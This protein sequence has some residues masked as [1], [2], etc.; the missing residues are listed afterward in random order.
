M[1]NDLIKREH[2]YLEDLTLKLIET[3][4]VRRQDKWKE[5]ILSIRE[6]I[7]SV[8]ESFGDEDSSTWRIHWDHQLYKVLE[9]HYASGLSS[10][11]DRLPDI[12]LDL[13]IRG[14]QI[15]FRPELENAR[16]RFYKEVKR[17]SQ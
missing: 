3:D 10:L 14:D 12:Q 8:K 13:V 15:S 5:I 9:L 16:A 4:L 2:K 1:K 7:H 11:V 17:F 6:K